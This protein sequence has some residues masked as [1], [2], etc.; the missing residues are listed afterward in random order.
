[1]R[2]LSRD[3][4]INLPPQRTNT[5]G[6]QYNAIHK[7]SK[8]YAYRVCNST[9]F[10]DKQHVTKGPPRTM[11]ASLALSYGPHLS[12]PFGTC[13]QVYDNTDNTTRSHTDNT[14]ALHL[15]GNANGGHFFLSLNSGHRISA[16][17]WTDLPIPNDVIMRVHTLARCSYSTPLHSWL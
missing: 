10:L 16:H 13:A 8:M 7:F 4:E 12:I 2:A 15:M 11:I 5:G 14:I 3:R 6:A 1:M 9:T 17:S